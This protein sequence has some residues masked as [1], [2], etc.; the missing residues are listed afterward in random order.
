MAFLPIACVGEQDPELRSLFSLIADLDTA[1]EETVSRYAGELGCQLLPTMSYG[2]SLHYVKYPLREAMKKAYSML[3]TVKTGVDEKGKLF[4]NKN[5]IGFS[6]QKH[7]GHTFKAFFEKGKEHETSYNC[8]KDLDRWQRASE[9]LMTGVVHRLSD[10]LFYE[11]FFQALFRG[12]LEPFLR[13]NFNE[14]VHRR[15][16]NTLNPFLSSLL[17]FSEAVYQDY[18]D[19]TKTNQV[20]FT[21]LRYLHFIQSKQD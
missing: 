14:G 12:C 5:A 6:L 1:F 20:L 3:E 17:K 16:D 21:A 10:P 7:S 4:P 19:R 9:D 8:L 18:Q 13:N 15:D 11:V 2:L